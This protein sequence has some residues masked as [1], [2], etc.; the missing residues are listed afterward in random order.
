MKLKGLSLFSN[1]GIA[2]LLLWKLDAEILIANELIENRANF[3]KEIYPKTL[4]ICDDIS[5]SEIKSK[6]IKESIKK[7]INFI[8]ATPPCQGMSTAG[9]K[10]NHNDPRNLLITHTIEIIEKINPKFI[11]FENVPGQHKTY[12]EIKKNKIL[13]PKYLEKKLSNNYIFNEN[14][15]FNMDGFR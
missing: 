7:E 15:I 2:E 6:L 10:N 3:Y 13:I 11:F 9:K 5:K 1:V 4:M 14:K 12:I 8:I